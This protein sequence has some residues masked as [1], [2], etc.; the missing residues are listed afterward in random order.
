[1]PAPILSKTSKKRAV[2]ALAP[3]GQP[4]QPIPVSFSLD[5]LPTAE[6]AT[7]SLEL[8][9]NSTAGTFCRVVALSETGLV[10]AVGGGGMRIYAQDG[11]GRVMYARASINFLSFAI[12]A[13]GCDVLTGGYDFS[14]VV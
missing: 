7:R 13:L 8:A 4:P 9:R 5:E 11:D 1:M 10:A 2:H 3:L 14:G 12:A 6:P